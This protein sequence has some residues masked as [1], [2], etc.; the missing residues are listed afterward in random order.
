MYH[1]S[2]QKV[3][4]IIYPMLYEH[5]RQVGFWRVNILIHSKTNVIYATKYNLD[6]NITM[7]KGSDLCNSFTHTFS[8]AI[9]NQS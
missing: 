1:L 5:R 9:K 7:P 8:I 2:F 3:K 4:I 6:K